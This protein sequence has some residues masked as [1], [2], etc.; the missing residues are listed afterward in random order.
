MSNMRKWATGS[1]LWALVL[2]SPVIAFLMIIMAEML[3]DLLIEAGA[4]ADFTV[5][6]GGIAWVLFRRTS[7][8]P[9][10]APRLGPERV[11]D[12]PAIAAPPT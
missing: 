3:I 7:S 8:H 9:E 4:I 12:E 10:K 5:A 11:S 2:L 6:A 1:V